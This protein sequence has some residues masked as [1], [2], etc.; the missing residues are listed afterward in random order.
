MFEWVRP[1]RFDRWRRRESIVDSRGAQST[2]RCRLRTAARVAHLSEGEQIVKYLMIIK[3]A[4]SYRSQPIRQGLLGPAFE[5]ECE[6]R[7][8]EDQ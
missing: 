2:L 1:G 5:A 7:P 8:L 6:V 4:E 3:H